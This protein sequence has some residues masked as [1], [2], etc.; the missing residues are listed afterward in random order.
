MFRLFVVYTGNVCEQST[1]SLY[2]SVSSYSHTTKRLVHPPGRKSRFLLITYFN[3]PF[4]PERVVGSFLWGGHG[5]KF[6][7]KDPTLLSEVD[8]L[9]FYCTVDLFLGSS[10][11]IRRTRGMSR[12]WKGDFVL[13]CSRVK[14]T[15]S[16][17]KKKSPSQ[18]ERERQTTGP[19]SRYLVSIECPRS[20][21]TRVP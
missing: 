5:L 18:R 2:L 21:R 11:V 12:M 13:N 10:L 6:L 19:T 15:G 9:P 3:N 20:L 8:Y 17:R 1:S 14:S 16:S 4:L 7:L